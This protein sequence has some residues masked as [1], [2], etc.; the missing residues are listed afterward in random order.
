M[1]FILNSEQFYNYSD[2][3]Y[4]NPTTQKKNN[5][6]LTPKEIILDK[7]FS[8]IRPGSSWITNRTILE[9]RKAQ[10]Q[11]CEGTWA[12][13]QALSI[14]KPSKK[15]TRDVLRAQRPLQTGSEV[16]GRFCASTRSIGR[17]QCDQCRTTPAARGVVN[18]LIFLF[19]RCQSYR[20][21]ASHCDGST[22]E[23]R[24]QSG[25]NQP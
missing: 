10:L 17:N 1:L 13:S 9:M 24:S 25:G 6:Y 14:H 8:F 15:Q 22:S 2:I 5:H 3:F 23:T 7:K 20:C 16:I 12:W 21:T 18:D 11:M 19:C 4:E